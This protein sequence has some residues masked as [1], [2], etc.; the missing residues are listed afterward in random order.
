MFFV[1]CFCAIQHLRYICAKIL[2]KTKI[3]R[4]LKLFLCP[5]K[6]FLKKNVQ[7]FLSSLKIKFLSFNIWIKTLRLIQ[8]FSQFY[9]SFFSGTFGHY[10]FSHMLDN[11]TFKL[12]IGLFACKRHRTQSRNAHVHINKVEPNKVYI[13]S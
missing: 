3:F 11:E 6:H 1:I 8:S 9:T 10:P 2:S 4:P 12:V 7:T 5:I 13:S